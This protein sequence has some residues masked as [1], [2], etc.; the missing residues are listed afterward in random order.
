[1]EITGHR[2]R[3]EKTLGFNLS[4]ALISWRLEEATGVTLIVVAVTALFK[5]PLTHLKKNN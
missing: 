3:S 5:R 1:M 4:E 2:S